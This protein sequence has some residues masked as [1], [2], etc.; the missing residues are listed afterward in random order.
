MEYVFKTGHSLILYQALILA[1]ERS[2]YWKDIQESTIGVVFFGVPHR[3]ADMAF[4]AECA[5][6]ILAF[7]S[8]GFVGSPSFAQVLKRNS[9]ELSKVSS[10][11]IQPASK[12]KT[13]RSF[14]ETEKLGN[15]IVSQALVGKRYVGPSTSRALT[16][17]IRSLTRT[18]LVFIQ[19]TR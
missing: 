8:L 3:G 11:F 17:N 19:P 13:I 16:R 7:A 4:W 18:R 9:P 6:N 5:A 10:A 12:I 15:D 2:E 1:N 14:Y